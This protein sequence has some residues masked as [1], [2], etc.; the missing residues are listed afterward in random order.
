MESEPMVFISMTMLCA[1]ELER[2]VRSV[3]LRGKPLPLPR[4][5][6]CARPLM[7]RAAWCWTCACPGEW[8]G[9]RRGWRR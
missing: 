3:G 7:V 5:L 6:A 1:Q 2:L 4:V 8:A 9:L